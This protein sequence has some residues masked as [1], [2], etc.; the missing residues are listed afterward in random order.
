MLFFCF[1]CFCKYTHSFQNGNP[2]PEKKSPPETGGDVFEGAV[3][4][5]ASQLFVQC[6]GGYFRVRADSLLS[7]SEE[8]ATRRG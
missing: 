7:V 3:G 5:A 8:E 1:C 2:Q 6:G 4:L